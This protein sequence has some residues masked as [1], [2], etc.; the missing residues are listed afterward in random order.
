MIDILMGVIS[1][2][3]VTTKKFYFI[4]LIVLD[5]LNVLKDHLLTT[6]YSKFILIL[7]LLFNFVNLFYFLI[8][9]FQY[10]YFFSRL[11][12]VFNL[13]L[14]Y[15]SW[16]CLLKFLVRTINC[17]IPIT[18]LINQLTTCFSNLLRKY[19][20]YVQHFTVSVCLRWVLSTIPYIV[21][22][23]VAFFYLLVPDWNKFQ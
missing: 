8:T 6:A 7:L 12:L 15:Q 1:S 9:I 18:T 23:S 2:M 13:L 22:L 5:L 21:L 11:K 10:T 19:N 20:F 17:V 3:N 16:Y 14:L 4:Q